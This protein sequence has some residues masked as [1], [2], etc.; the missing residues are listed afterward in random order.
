ML[1]RRLHL[2]LATWL[3]QWPAGPGLHVVGSGRR[4]RPAW[5]GRP[6]PAIAVHAGAS[7]VLSVAPDRVAAVRELVRRPDGLL[8]A[9]PAAVG[10]PRWAVHDD[11]F[12]WSVAPADLPDV[13]EW[14]PP[15][16]PGLPS[17]LRLFDRSVLVV[18]DQRGRYLAGVGIKR[19]DRHGHEL[20]VGTVPAARGRGLARRLVAQAARRVLDDGAVPTYLHDRS[21]A[22][23][24]RVA[25]AAGFPDRGWRSYGVYP[26]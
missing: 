19:H 7:G 16:T 11:V 2:H 23:S 12:R 6:R 3:G 10:Y 5:D 18:R 17:W 8:N 14:A 21:N 9:L 1:D 25:E 13:G 24:A 15:T 22:A 20:A 26:S 4:T